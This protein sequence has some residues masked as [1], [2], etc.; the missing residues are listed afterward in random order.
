MYRDGEDANATEFQELLD[1]L[2]TVGNPIFFRL[3]EL[4]ARPAAVEHAH[5][6]IDELKEWKANK[7][8]FPQEQ[9][10]EIIKNLRIGWMTKKLI[11]R[12]LLDSGSPHLSLKQY[13]QRCL[14]CKTRFPVL[15][16]FPSKIHDELC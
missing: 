9:V 6:Y 3:K 14:I 2:K 15:I 4:T 12:R 11:K 10:Y 8:W 5:R 7:S 1:Q 16:E 13:I